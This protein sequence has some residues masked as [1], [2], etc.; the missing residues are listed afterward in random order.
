MILFGKNGQ[1]K[2]KNEKHRNAYRSA[3]ER[4][5]RK[6]RLKFSLLGKR[7]A[8]AET[9]IYAVLGFLAIISL[10]GHY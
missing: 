6:P 5:I 9:G 1:R 4:E 8:I 10:M 2:C 3:N 7:C